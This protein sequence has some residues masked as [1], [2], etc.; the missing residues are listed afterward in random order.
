MVVISP[1]LEALGRAGKLHV[2]GDCECGETHQVAPF[3]I[4]GPKG[5]RA[6]KYPDSFRVATGNRYQVAQWETVEMPHFTRLFSIRRT[7]GVI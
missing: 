6:S 7:V 3:V 1:E 5:Y 2:L 4:A